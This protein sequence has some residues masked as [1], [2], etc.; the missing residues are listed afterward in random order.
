MV[1]Y[2]C[3][4]KGHMAKECWQPQKV[5]QVEEEMRSSAGVSM[6]AGSTATSSQVKQVRLVTPPDAPC[7]EIFDLD[8]GQDYDGEA[9]GSWA[10]WSELGVIMVHVEA[11]VSR[12][13]F[14]EC[15]ELGFEVPTGVP[16]I[17]MHLQDDDEIEAEKVETD[18]EQRVCMISSGSRDSGGSVWHEVTLD[19]G[20]DL[21]V[22]PMSFLNV[23]EPVED[24]ERMRMV[25][26]QGKRIQYAGITK[27]SLLVKGWNNQ[28]IIINEKFVVGN[29]K[30]PLLCAGKMLRQ[31]W[32]VKHGTH[33]LCLSHGEKQVEIPLQ[34][35]KNS[36]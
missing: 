18:N 16:V 20:A 32:E 19:S 27:A 10:D 25:D 4:R 17:G 8:D 9:R 3:G 31:G 33:G 24:D 14:H 28:E 36:L 11:D 5:Q 29:V 1:C 21:S 30:T 13:E 23:G 12:L 26:A 34:M 7:V 15:E 2:N 35:S 22:L 6:A